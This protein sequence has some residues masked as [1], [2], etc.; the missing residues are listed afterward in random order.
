VTFGDSGIAAGGRSDGPPGKFRLYPNF[1]NP[2]N[3][4]TRFRFSLDGPARVTL[5]VFD[6]RGRRIRLLADGVSP[7]GMHE[8][9]W[10]GTDDA[11]NQVPSGVYFCRLRTESG[12]SLQKMLLLR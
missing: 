5:D 4:V 8:T 1:P 11:G 9:F 3:P 7:R 6:A 10:D 12:T 2:F